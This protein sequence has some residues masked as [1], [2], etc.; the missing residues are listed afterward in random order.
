MG[1]FVATSLMGS[2]VANHN[3]HQAEIAY[4]QRGI[5]H[6]SLEM[7]LPNE[8]YGALHMRCSRFLNLRY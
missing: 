2:S 7:H 6:L 8:L 1:R 5:K 4:H 3:L